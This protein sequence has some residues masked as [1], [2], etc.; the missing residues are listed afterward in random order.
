MD[1]EDVISQ[2]RNC[3]VCTEALPL[4]ANPIVQASVRSKIV[5]IG[6]APG[7]KA[8]LS[9][10]PWNDPSGIRLRDWLEVTDEQF[11]NSGLFALLPMGF[12]YPGK[13]ATGDMP[14]RKECAPLW[15]HLLLEEMKEVRLVLLVGKYAQHYY[16]KNKQSLTENIRHYADFLPQYF[17]L[18]HPS[19][20]NFIW[21]NQNPWFQSEVLP[22]LRKLVKTALKI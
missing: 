9:R 1:F 20:R 22:D 14:P 13:A 16:L 8:H 21:M 18:P 19:P 7:L 2:V 17:P 5:I 4:G 10:I 6:Q 12:C 3:I 11:Y 15:H